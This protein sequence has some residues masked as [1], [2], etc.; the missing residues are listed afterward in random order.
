[1]T[2][3]F[4]D[5]AILDSFL[6]S[7]DSATVDEGDPLQLF[8][9]HSGSLPAADIMWTLDGNA[10][11]PSDRI[12]VLSLQLSGT[13]PPQTSSSLYISSTE[14]SDGGSYVCEAR[15]E[16]LPDVVVTSNSGDVTIIGK[17]N[18][19]TISTNIKKYILW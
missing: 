13:D 19:R 8:C 16:L 12:S 5:L 14:P 9:I 6:V 3:P 10:V 7:P 18:I 2:L 4:S 15:N 1:M 11:E 17:Q